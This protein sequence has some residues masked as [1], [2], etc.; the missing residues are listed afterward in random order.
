MSRPT[1]LDVI[2]EARRW[3]GTPFHHQG[4]LLGVG[5]D[6]AGLVVGVAR[7]LGVCDYDVAGYGREPYQG[8]LQRE[9]EGQLTPIAVP[10]PGAVL[11]MR[12][13]TEPQHLGIYTS[14]DTIVH[15]YEHVGRC[16]EHRF[17]DVWRA[18]VVQSYV[19]P[20]VDRWQ[21]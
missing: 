17:S 11:L 9:V 21:P 7:A 1:W 6:C 20:G 5:V 18:R 4:R 8:L 13:Q 12:F 15:A 2:C 10:E 19:L 3:I 16:L 14:S